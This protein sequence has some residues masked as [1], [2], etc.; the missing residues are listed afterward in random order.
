MGNIDEAISDFIG[1]E[2]MQGTG[3]P[4]ADT[5]LLQDEI[6]DS[7]GIFT[8]VGFVESQFKVKVEPEEV[9]IGN[10]ESVSAI[11]KLV[12]SKL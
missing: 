1:N 2:F 9:N 12:E 7:L 10:F 5:N 3:R 11:A 4:E 6:I 8:L